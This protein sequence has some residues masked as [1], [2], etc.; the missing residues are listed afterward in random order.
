MIEMFFITVKY[1][2][3]KLVQE[4]RFALNSFYRKQLCQLMPKGKGDLMS[5]TQTYNI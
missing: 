4:R 2:H 1:Y 3:H 5:A